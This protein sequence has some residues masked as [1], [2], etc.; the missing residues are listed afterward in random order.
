M[1]PSFWSWEKYTEDDT[2]CNES[3]VAMEPSFW[4]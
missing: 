2:L 4:S 3:D 1:E